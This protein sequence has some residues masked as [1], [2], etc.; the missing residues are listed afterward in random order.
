MTGAQTNGIKRKSLR[1]H[2]D[3][4]DDDDRPVK[5]PK[6]TST[7]TSSRNASQ[8]TL[9][10]AKKCEFALSNKYTRANADALATS[11]R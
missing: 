10:K 6:P 8:N 7:T 11:L 3:H 4:P 5:K 2:N 9:K 1:H